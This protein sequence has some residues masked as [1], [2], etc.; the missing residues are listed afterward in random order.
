VTRCGRAAMLDE[1][2]ALLALVEDGLGGADCLDTGVR[3][4][5]T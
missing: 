5:N 1:P 2:L 4:A 3:P